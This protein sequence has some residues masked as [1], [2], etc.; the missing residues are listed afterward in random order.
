[1]SEGGTV[2]DT[3]STGSRLTGLTRL[4][5]ARAGR[6]GLA[7]VLVAVWLVMLLLLPSHPLAS[8][9][10]GSTTGK[11]GSKSGPALVPG[12]APGV[13][14]DTSST[15]AG[16]GTGPT[17]RPG[18]GAGGAAGA[19]AG[20]SRGGV[21]CGPGVRQLPGDS[22][23]APCVPAFAGS[24]GGATARG[25]TA[26]TIR[27]VR[28]AFPDSANSQAVDAV[29]AQAG[30]ASQ[31]LIR[32]TRAK[33][34]P[35]FDA[36][37]ELYGRH[38]EWV[39]YVS[40]YGDETQ[41]TQGRG[42]EGACLDAEVVANEL[43][44]FAVLSDKG[45]VSKPFTECAVQRGLVVL[46]GASY[47]SEKFYADRHPYAWAL[48]MDCQRINYQVAEYLAKRLANRPA[49]WAGDPAL[50]K[51]TRKFGV[52]TPA[53]DGSD[54]TCS[55]VASS[56][57]T[58]YGYDST[59][60]YQ[61]VLDVSRFPDEAARGA[62]Q[63]KRDGVTTVVMACDPISMIFLSQSATSQG[64]HPE[65]FLIGI[66]LTDVDNA[67]RLYDQGQVD[68][69]MFG[70][71][72]LGATS[73]ILGPLG[74]PGKLYQRLT[75]QVIPAGTDGQFYELTH[76][77]NLLQ[78]AG[79]TLTPQNLGAG[80]FA[81]PPGGGPDYATGYW[82]FQDG[83]DGTPG[84]HDHTELDDSREVYWRGD[85]RSPNDGKAGTYIETMGGRRFRNG[86]W[87]SGEPPVYPER[88]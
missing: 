38:V 50:A 34:L 78:S 47:A 32:A 15:I 9:T 77:Y 88:G 60:N 28:R 20:V 57:A 11:S 84:A 69:H 4:V 72:Q 44:A 83:P 81:L 22:Y 13:S 53:G 3:T 40:R 82:S 59:S 18:T 49:R 8:R 68:G 79:S 65:W 58:R 31:Q 1:V 55:K 70:M 52:Y 51:Q 66:I 74:E 87:P 16:G 75:G 36:K 43:H 2:D 30:G 17:A 12:A 45:A 85:V 41:E 46:D 10:A 71:S 25:V 54:D 5:P 6:F 14:L 33:L 21:T 35:E 42:R 63:L 64:W 76:V 7:Y 61:Y 48:I 56:E 80:A 86:E 26:T 37:Y 62:I 39:D 67:A 73:K 24:N 29:V 27:V 23:A 19:T